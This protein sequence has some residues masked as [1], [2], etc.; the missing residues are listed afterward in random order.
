MRPECQ[1]LSGSYYSFT[2][3]SQMRGLTSTLLICIRYLFSWGKFKFAQLSVPQQ[4]KSCTWKVLRT[5]KYPQRGE[6]ELTLLSRVYSLETFWPLFP[7]VSKVSPN[8]KL[9]IIFWFPFRRK[10]LLS[11][12]LW[13]SIRGGKE[14]LLSQHIH[15]GWVT[16][17][18]TAF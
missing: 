1:S 16:S 15:H 4:V 9:W 5:R 10:E 17:P 18:I 8:I 2:E 14:W 7:S 3:A 12:Q 6:E 11:P 13:G